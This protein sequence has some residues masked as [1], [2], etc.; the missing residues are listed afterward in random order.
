MLYSHIHF[1]EKE[2]KTQIALEAIKQFLVLSISPVC[3]N[4]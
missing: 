2:K 4:I 3:D 1:A